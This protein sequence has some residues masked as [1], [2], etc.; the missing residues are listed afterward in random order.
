MNLEFSFCKTSCHTRIKSPVCPTVSPLLCYIVIYWFMQKYTYIC[1]IHT[2]AMINRRTQD[3]DAMIKTQ[4]DF[5]IKIYLLLT[6]FV[7]VRK[8]CSRFACEREMETEHNWNIF[9]P[10][11]MA[12][13]VVSFSFSMAAQPEPWSPLYWVLAFLTTSRPTPTPTLLNSTVQFVGHILPSNSHAVIR[14]R[15][16]AS[17]ISSDIWRSG[18]VT[19]GIFGMALCDRH[20]AEITVM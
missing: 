20:R 19:S 2:D 17:A 6:L 10:E 7:R 3:K 18:C 15:L 16:Y 14:T 4:E 1:W 8:G 9:D 13:S 11:V 12:V 5:F